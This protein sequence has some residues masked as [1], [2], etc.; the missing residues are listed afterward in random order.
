MRHLCFLF[1]FFILAFM[2]NQ[3]SSG[4]ELEKPPEY[5]INRGDVINVS[6]MEHPE[7]TIGNITVLPDGTIQYPGLGSIIA[8]GM[9][10]SRL[11]D[12]I[13]SALTH[14]V[15]EPIV[16]IY[17][18]KIEKEKI[19]IFGYVN[20]PG[21]YQLF[22]GTELLYAIGMAGGI[23]DVKKVRDITIIRTNGAYEIIKIK[24][25]FP[26]NGKAAEMPIVYA[27][28]IIYIKA[29]DGTNWARWSFVCSLITAIA[30]M[31]NIFV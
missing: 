29:P 31:I 15:V 13:K 19:S 8:A 23:K 10:S 4:Q 17:V 9:S 5:I 16:T 20:K 30:Y 18:S 14:Y 24:H 25:L 22:E 12:S 3:A 27:G 6:V 2:L 7:F 26:K 11:Q 28:D 21:Q 1:N